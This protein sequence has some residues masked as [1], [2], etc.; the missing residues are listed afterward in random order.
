MYK[1]DQVIDKTSFSS[2]DYTKT[3]LGLQDATVKQSVD[4]LLKDGH[5]DSSS[6]PK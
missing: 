5:I 6:I 1:K 4:S 3:L 2:E